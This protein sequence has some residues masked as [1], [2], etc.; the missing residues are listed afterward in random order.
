MSTIY[1]ASLASCVPGSLTRVMSFTLWRI[2]SWCANRIMKQR[3]QKV[4]DSFQIQYYLQLLENLHFQRKFIGKDKEMA[5][6]LF[7]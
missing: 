5:V 2:E 7:T 1:N 6:H 4:S 3:S